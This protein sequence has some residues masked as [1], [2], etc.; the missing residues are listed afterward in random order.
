MSF[1]GLG[2]WLLAL[3]VAAVVVASEVYAIGAL[4]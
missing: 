1:D 3:L 2:L 4:R